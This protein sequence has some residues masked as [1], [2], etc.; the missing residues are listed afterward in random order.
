MLFRVDAKLSNN[1]NHSLDFFKPIISFTIR[2]WIFV[3]W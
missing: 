1:G 2:P 3:F